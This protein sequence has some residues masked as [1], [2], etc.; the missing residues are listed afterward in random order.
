[1]LKLNH[2]LDPEPKP[3]AAASEGWRLESYNMFMN[4]DPLPVEGA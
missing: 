2:M 4:C 1:M 3:Q